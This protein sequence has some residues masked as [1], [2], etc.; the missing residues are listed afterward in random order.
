VFGELFDRR[1]FDPVDQQYFNDNFD[2]AN[3]RFA[4]RSN[5]FWFDYTAD[6][7]DGWIP[8]HAVTRQL[9][10]Q[11]LDVAGDRPSARQHTRIRRGRG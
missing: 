6:T 7:G 3:S 2:F 4:S 11:T 9:A 8:A 5:D 10:R 1:E